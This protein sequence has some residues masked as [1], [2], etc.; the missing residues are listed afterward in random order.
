MLLIDGCGLN[1]ELAIDNALGEQ[2]HGARVLILDDL[3]GYL[4]YKIYDALIRDP[5]Y[6]L[7]AHNPELR[8]GYAIFKKLPAAIASA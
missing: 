2:L 1:R 3:N 8:N 6:F 7:S 4:N 5:S